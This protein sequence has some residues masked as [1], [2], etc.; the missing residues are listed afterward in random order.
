[1][2][3]GCACFSAVVR[4]R[5]AQ[6]TEHHGIASVDFSIVAFV[7]SLGAG[8]RTVCLGV[9]DALPH[10]HVPE[11]ILGT[12]KKSLALSSKKIVKEPQRGMNRCS[13][14]KIWLTASKRCSKNSNCLR[15][16]KL[17]KQS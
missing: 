3:D 14:E 11:A 13:L 12:A 16:A 17:A 6:R 2:C 9:V 4:I 7:L 1:M 10:G 8:L 15:R 5:L